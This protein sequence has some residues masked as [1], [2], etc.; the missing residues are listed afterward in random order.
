MDDE[1]CVQL[2]QGEK[3]DAGHLRWYQRKLKDM[4]AAV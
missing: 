2:L 4:F 3:A 1:S